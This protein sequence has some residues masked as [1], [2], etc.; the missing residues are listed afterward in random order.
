[1]TFN[2]PLLEPY[3][4][5]TLIP[6]AYLI[7]SFVSAQEAAYLLNKIEELAGTEQSTDETGPTRVFKS[8]GTAQGWRTVSGRRLMT[9]GGQVL[10]KSSTLIPVALPA[11]MSSA[12]PNVI[13]RVKS[14]TGAFETARGKGPNHV[15]LMVKVSINAEV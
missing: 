12:F 4:L 14:K 7:P 1:M 2:I 10:E 6:A 15:S 9:W 5:N 8:K 3:R 13:E 11:F